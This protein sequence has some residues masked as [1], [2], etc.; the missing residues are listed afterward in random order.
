MVSRRG[1]AV[2]QF[3]GKIEGW[4]RWRRCVRRYMAGVFQKLHP[5]SHAVARSVADGQF[6]HDTALHPC[7]R[8]SRFQRWPTKEARWKTRELK[9]ERREERNGG[10]K[11]KAT[12]QGSH[13]KTHTH[14]AKQSSRISSPVSALFYHSPLP[15]CT[16]PSPL[17]PPSHCPH[18]NSMKHNPQNTKQSPH[19]HSPHRVI[20]IPPFPCRGEGQCNR[21]SEIA[22]G[23]GPAPSL[24][25]ARCHG[26][27]TR[28]DRWCWCCARLRSR[29]RLD[30]DERR[31]S[32][33]WLT[34]PP[35]PCR[36]DETVETQ[37]HNT[38]Q[39]KTRAEAQ[40]VLRAVGP[41]YVVYYVVRSIGLQRRADLR[42]VQPPQQGAQVSGLSV[43]RGIPTRPFHTNHR[44]TDRCTCRAGVACGEFSRQ[45]GWRISSRNA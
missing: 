7:F 41:V 1:A 35:C 43:S 17:V 32:S 5:D 34:W 24:R 3:S 21:V 31:S 10:A 15:L 45:V 28:P 18:S 26:E 4:I 12:H 42:R 30:Q 14:Y 9:E 39:D 40:A 23:F 2:P 33:R 25:D 29:S 13:S 27:P 8:I 44:A 16:H 6:H 37:H 36:A 19:P 38:T 22:L 20:L 11:E